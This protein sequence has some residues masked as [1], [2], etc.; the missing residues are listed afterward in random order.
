MFDGDTV[1][2]VPDFV[3]SHRLGGES[4][5]PMP[6]IPPWPALRK[7]FERLGKELPLEPN[8]FPAPAVWIQ[9]GNET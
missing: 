3:V 9:R 1:E 8:A 2:T 7:A 5:R 4:A 6:V